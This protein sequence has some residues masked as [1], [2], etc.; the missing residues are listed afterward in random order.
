MG[1]IQHGFQQSSTICNIC[2]LHR[3][4]HV[5][6]FLTC[7]NGCR[8]SETQAKSI[9]KAIRHPS[10]VRNKS[11]GIDNIRVVAEITP[12][13]FSCPTCGVQKSM[14]QAMQCHRVQAHQWCHPI[15]KRVPI[16]PPNS[17]VCLA[18]GKMY[19]SRM[20]LLAHLMEQSPNCALH[21]LSTIPPITA[22]ALEDVEAVDLKQ[23][24]RDNRQGF[25]RNTRRR[26]P[27]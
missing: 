3:H 6:P 8:C 22:K 13:S 26:N 16:Q 19:R 15:R 12:D 27:M 14:Y 2:V 9:R 4:F 20:S 21:Y 17:A 23:V 10:F 18:C 7:R 11:Q 1:S 24:Q 5:L 25:R